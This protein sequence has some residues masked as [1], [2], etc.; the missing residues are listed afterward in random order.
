MIFLDIYPT[1]S[2][3]SRE[4]ANLTERKNPHT[5]VYG[6]K[7]TGWQR[8]STCQQANIKSGIKK[9]LCFFLQFDQVVYAIVRSKL[10]S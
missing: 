5:P 10:Y 6:V 1:A 9:I 8:C 2:E 3:A 4:V 7:E